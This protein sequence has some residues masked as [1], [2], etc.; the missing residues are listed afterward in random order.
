MRGVISLLWITF[1]VRVYHLGHF[2]VVRYHVLVSKL[3]LVGPYF[4]N[5]DSLCAKYF[6]T[7]HL[8]HRIS[9]A[10]ADYRV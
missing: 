1:L 5:E 4:R 2:V 10:I 8:N 9:H 6:L 7:L 3:F